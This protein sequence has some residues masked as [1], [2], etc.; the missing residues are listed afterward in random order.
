M[1][2]RRR[3]S[4]DVG[5][6][7]LTAA[8]A[9][10]VVSG[11]SVGIPALNV[12]RLTDLRNVRYEIEAIAGG[13]AAANREESDL[14]DLARYL[15]AMQATN[16]SGDVKGYLRAN[17]GFHFAIYRAAK[18]ENLLRIVEDLW[19][20]ISP[21]FNMLHESGNYSTANTHHET[22]YTALRDRDAKTLR[23]AVREDIDGAYQVLLKLFR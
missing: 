1:G 2:G 19:L 14:P 21:Y 16:A 12:E 4:A 9:L 11:R 20:Q 22:M 7:R 3:T 6:L 23:A 10:T 13:W 15:E 18:S 17:Y 8:N 5:G